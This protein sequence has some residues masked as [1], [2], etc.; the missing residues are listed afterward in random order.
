[1]GIHIQRRTRGARV[2]C[3][4]S[5]RLEV[6]SHVGRMIENDRRGIEGYQALLGTAAAE[7]SSCEVLLYLWLSGVGLSVAH[8]F[9]L[10]NSDG[11][12][13]ELL[14][15]TWTSRLARLKIGG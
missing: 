1:M 4:N 11:Q 9:T 2:E 10:L 15:F 5:V 14:A 8:W 12:G 13:L 7:R 6:C 3:K